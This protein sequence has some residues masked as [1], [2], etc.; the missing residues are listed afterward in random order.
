MVIEPVFHPRL[1]GSRDVRRA[2]IVCSNQ[3]ELPGSPE[4][5]EEG[6]AILSR[7]EPRSR[8]LSFAAWLMVLATARAVLPA[9]TAAWAS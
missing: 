8:R 3:K 2:Q 7:S 5:F 9:A 1:V 4:L 6:A